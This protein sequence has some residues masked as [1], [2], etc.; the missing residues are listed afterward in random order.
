MLTDLSRPLWFSFT[1]SLRHNLVSDQ[2]NMQPYTCKLKL[3]PWQISS[4]QLHLYQRILK[5]K[6]LSQLTLDYLAPSLFGNWFNNN[7]NLKQL[8][9]RSCCKRIDAR[10]MFMLYTYCRYN[11]T[12][13]VCLDPTHIRC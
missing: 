13:I 6:F 5:P 12:A 4:V 7:I 9:I 2:C 8:Q 3:F 10:L 11:R 1:H